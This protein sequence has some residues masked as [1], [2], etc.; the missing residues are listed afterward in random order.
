[1]TPIITPTDYNCAENLFNSL[2]FICKNTVYLNKT[3]TPKIMDIFN[4][5]S[6]FKLKFI[7]FKENTQCPICGNKLNKNIEKISTINKKYGKIKH[8]PNTKRKKIHTP[9]FFKKESIFQKKIKKK[10]KKN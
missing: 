6:L 1:M 2:Y 4:E 9:S 7:Y 3:V 5:L 8:R 10:I